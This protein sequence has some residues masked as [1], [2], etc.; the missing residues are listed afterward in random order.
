MILGKNVTFICVRK[1]Y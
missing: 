1:Y